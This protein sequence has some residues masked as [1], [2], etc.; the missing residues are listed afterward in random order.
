[1]DTTVC[2]YNGKHNSGLFLGAG[3][4]NY[5]LYNNATFVNSAVGANEGFPA[6]QFVNRKILTT[7]NAHYYNILPNEYCS[8]AQ[9]TTC[10]LATPA[11]LSPG[12]GFLNAAPVRWCKAVNDTQLSTAVSGKHGRPAGHPALPQE[13]R[14]DHAPL[15][16]LRSFRARGRRRHRDLPE[17][18]EFHAQ[19]LRG[20]RAPTPKRSRTSPTGT[21]TTASGWRS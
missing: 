15:P 9:L 2:R 12:G 18:A 14:Q 20:G 5:F 13:V 1:M 7:S 21:A 11:G 6:Q 8:D 3:A 19:R 10:A 4:P 17:R 16:A